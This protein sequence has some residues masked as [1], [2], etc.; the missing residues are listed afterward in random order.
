MEKRK[1]GESSG[2]SGQTFLEISSG[3]GEG[4][5]A[6]MGNCEEMKTV[7]LRE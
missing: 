2:F 5:V 7:V 1:S 6:R 4:K 3:S